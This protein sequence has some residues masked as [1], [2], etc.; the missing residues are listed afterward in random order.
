MVGALPALLTVACTTTGVGHG[1]SISPPPQDD[2]PSPSASPSPTASPGPASA[3]GSGVATVSLSGDLTLTAPFATLA[4]PAVWAPPPAPMDI[5]WEGTQEQELH[6][7][8]TS[9]VSR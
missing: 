3:L 7:S 9:F 1:A 5:T 4:I 8:G 2:S 6:L